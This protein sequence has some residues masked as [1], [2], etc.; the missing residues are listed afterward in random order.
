MNLTP[1]Q[2]KDQADAIAA[3]VDNWCEACAIRAD[4]IRMEM[5][6]PKHAKCPIHEEQPDG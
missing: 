5:M 2:A 1:E 6:D 3:M 4:F